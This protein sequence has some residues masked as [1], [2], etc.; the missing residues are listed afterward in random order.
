MKRRLEKHGIT[1]V[2]ALWNASAIDLCR[3][4]G[5]VLGERWWYMLRGSH[6]ADYQPA[7]FSTVK[8]SVGRSNVLAPEHRTT[9]AAKKIL[10]E[11]PLCYPE[12]LENEEMWE[13]V[14]AEEEAP[15][16]REIFA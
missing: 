2:E 5:S 16:E 13:T 14:R 7:Q 3:A 11:Y 8:K 6:E 9:E 1:T 15:K 4:W 10:S 12:I